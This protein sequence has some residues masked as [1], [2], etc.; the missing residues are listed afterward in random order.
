MPKVIKKKV[1]DK[2]T[3]QDTE[4][5]GFALEALDAAKEKQKQI[6]TG[7]VIIAAILALYMTFSMYSA[8][9]EAD[10][11]VVEMKANNFYYGEVIKGSMSDEDKL[12]KAIEIFKESVDIKPSR[13]ALFN[14]GN[15][16]YKLEDFG[17]A[18]EQ[19]E[20][21]IK[22]F[23]DN[24]ELLPLVY[25]K[26]AASYFRSGQ[27]D[28]AFDALGKL[29]RVGGGMFKDTAL[30]LEARYLESAGDAGKSIAKYQ[31]LM[32]EFP[33]SIWSQ[34]AASK[35]PAPE[36]EEKAEEKIEEE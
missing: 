22:E 11:S 19:Y 36:T 5:Q 16:Y 1:D 34:E 8:S 13:T 14:L 31:E 6:I 28:K 10:A 32:A 33:G 9:I 26:M 4:V 27:Q 25:Q 3:V 20:L 24:K 17:N 2:K 30:M 18:I 21:F 12:K 29:A 23:S 7:A 35:L 15:A